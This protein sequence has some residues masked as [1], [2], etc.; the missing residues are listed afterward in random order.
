MAITF[1]QERKRQK[2]LILVLTILILA[3]SIVVWN[4]FFKKERALAPEKV[5]AP[6]EIKINFEVLKSPIFEEFQSFEPILSLEEEAL[7][8]GEEVKI[9][10]EN[11]FAPYETGIKTTE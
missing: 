7:K 2:Y 11:P 6:P 8:K 4:N 5:Y 1:F 9:G 10:R 3:I